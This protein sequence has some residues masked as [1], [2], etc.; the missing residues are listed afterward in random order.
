MDTLKL[1][2]ISLGSLAKRW[3]IGLFGASFWR[4][5]QFWAVVGLVSAGV[6]ALVLAPAFAQQAASA[7]TN[8]RPS[9]STGREIGKLVA[10]I[11]G[12]VFQYVVAFEGFVLT[13]LVNYA[14]VPVAQ[15]NDFVKSGA[16]ETGWFI[17]RDVV[18]M[19]YVLILIV[20][21]FR[22]ILGIG[23]G[24]EK[25]L[26]RLIISAVVVNFSRSICGFFIDFAQVVMLT[27]VNAFSQAAGGNFAKAFQIEKMLAYQANLDS[28]SVEPW[29]LVAGFILAVILIGFS[30]AM[31]FYITIILIL[32]IV[33]LWFLVVL[34]PLA[35]FLQAVP[36]KST[37]GYYARWWGLFT[38]KTVTGPVLA[39]FLWLSLVVVADDRLT[40]GVPQNATTEGARVTIPTEVFQPIHI[41]NYLIAMAMLYIGTMVSQEMGNMTYSAVTG[42]TS[43]GVRRVLSGAVSTGQYVSQRTP[44]GR[45]VTVAKSAGFGVLAQ[46]PGL[47]SVG[48]AGLSRLQDQEAKR[49]S[50]LAK[51]FSGLDSAQRAD[52]Y[53]SMVRRPDFMKSA[54]QRALQKRLGAEVLDGMMIG[55]GYTEVKRRAGETD[56]QFKTRE[57]EARRKEFMAVKRSTARLAEA[58]HDSDTM[59]KIEDNIDKK[60][61]DLIVDFDEA[62]PVRAEKQKEDL[63]KAAGKIGQNQFLDMSDKAMTGEVIMSMRA[64]MIENS[65]K[66]GKLND[67]QVRALQKLGITENMSAEEIAVQQERL[68]EKNSQY[69]T[70]DKRGKL[71]GAHIDEMKRQQAAADAAGASG[72]TAAKAAAETA[73]DAAA[74]R[75]LKVGST[76]ARQDHMDALAAA[77]QGAKVAAMINSGELKVDGRELAKNEAL[78]GQ[79]AKNLS[80]D[81]IKRTARDTQTAIMAGLLDEIKKASAAG[82][83]D[84][85]TKLAAKAV[86]AGHDV[87]QAFGYDRGR[88]DDTRRAALQG[89]VKASDQ[90]DPAA[91]VAAQVERLKSISAE[92]LSQGGVRND[93]MQVVAGN[94]SNEALKGLSNDA[95]GREK[96]SQMIRQL[97]DAVAM[98]VADM[99]RNI[100]DPVAA[101]AE[102]RR[103]AEYQRAATAKLAE[104]TRGD[105]GNMVSVIERRVSAARRTGGGGGAAAGAGGGTV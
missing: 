88:I 79:V 59:K 55:E 15:Y 74:D 78:R 41:Q 70:A 100:A 57:Y 24:Y 3:A 69:L 80:A 13:F 101:A 99:T 84:E 10:I 58:S 5:W 86:D 34:S 96:I 68:K 52:L 42:K 90:T 44:I 76:L 83:H 61:P 92:Q 50:D 47:R 87:G 17:I 85:A 30:I 91:R 21:A 7:A 46:I 63:A 22:T 11:M 97:H 1:N 38:Q 56:D 67:Y 77:G 35:F 12:Y 19:F 73:R 20:I 104:I 103:L 26:P 53:R 89:W 23:E 75:A 32:R 25:A 29:G 54:D 14:L 2:L 62:D 95:G 48:A 71:S 72:D 60:R 81:D 45:G 36:A 40:K 8:A 49:G 6:L 28:P 31:V 105:A 102:S 82:N 39:F 65:L 9:T 4:S 98:N 94:I 33:Y 37:G 18:N 27:F 64:G 93:V 66:S 16:V 43:A 51:R